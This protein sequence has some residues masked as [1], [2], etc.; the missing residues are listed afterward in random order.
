MTPDTAITALF[1]LLAGIWTAVCILKR[2]STLKSCDKELRLR[3]YRKAEART[4]RLPTGHVRTSEYRYACLPGYI[5][6][7]NP[8]LL[9]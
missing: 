8:N 2:V 5:V 4:M 6:A 7:I 9:K 1:F 3:L